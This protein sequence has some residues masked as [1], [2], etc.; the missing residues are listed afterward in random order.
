MAR[1][2]GIHRESTQELCVLLGSGS[3]RDDRAGS[4]TGLVSGKGC[5]N[6]DSR[7]RPEGYRLCTYE[8]IIE[9]DAIKSAIAVAGAVYHL[10][11]RDEMLPRFTKEQM[12]APPPSPSPTP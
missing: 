10:A 9:D 4:A 3:G 2:L 11:T 8:R 12:P 7:E 5:S 6:A 1:L